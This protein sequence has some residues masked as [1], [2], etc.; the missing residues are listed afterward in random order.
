MLCSIEGT[1]RDGRVELAET[2]PGMP[3]SRVIV[4]FLGPAKVDEDSPAAPYDGMI[5]NRG[6]GPQIAS[7]R[8]TVYDIMD[9][10]LEGWEPNKIAELFRLREAEVLAAFRYID[11]HKAEVEAHYR[12]ILERHSRGN[13]PEVEAMR[14][15]SRQK[16]REWFTSRGKPVPQQLRD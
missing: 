1:F 11:E 9:Y 7:S 8:I 2:P 13:R 12:A 4:T 10:R 15:E 16:L 5:V 14:A 3:E 6:R